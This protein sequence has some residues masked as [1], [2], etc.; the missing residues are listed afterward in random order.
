MEALKTRDGRV[1][2]VYIVPKALQFIAPEHQVP[3]V[4]IAA[5]TRWGGG[6]LKFMSAKAQREAGPAHGAAQGTLDEPRNASHVLPQCKN[7][8]R[9]KRLSLGGQ[10]CAEDT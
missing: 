8:A 9:S 7:R 1:F 6:Q 2:A 5:L 3:E 4:C 10:R